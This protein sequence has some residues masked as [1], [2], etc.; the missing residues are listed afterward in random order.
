MN[1]I[2]PLTGTPERAAPPIV[3][4]P[5]AHPLPGHEVHALLSRWGEVEA[6]PNKNLGAID[7]LA[8]SASTTLKDNRLA[9]RRVFKKTPGILA[10]PTG[11]QS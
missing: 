4:Q 6:E 2:P 5:L 8:R 3:Q 10:A 7:A 9:E 1:S 11:L